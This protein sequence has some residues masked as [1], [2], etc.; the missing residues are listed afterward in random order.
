MDLFLTHTETEEHSI[1]TNGLT[2]DTYR[3]RG[4][5]NTYKEHKTSKQKIKTLKQYI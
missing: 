5:F 1:P 2:P 4:T 3:D